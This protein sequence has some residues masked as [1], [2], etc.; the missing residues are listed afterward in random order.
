MTLTTFNERRADGERSWRFTISGIYTA[1]EEGAS[2][3]GLIGHYAYFN[4]GL[5]SGPDRVSW[6]VLKARDAAAN[7]ALAR[8]IDD[9]FANSAAATRTQSEAA[10][11]R[12]FLA[13]VGDIVGIVRLIVGAA[14]V[15]ILFVVGNTMVFSIAERT[16]EIGV[17]KTLGFS[18]GR[19]ARLVGGEALVLAV[20]GGLTGLALAALIVGAI[21]EP[22][23]DVLPGVA[24]TGSI[25]ATALGLMVL[26]ALLTGFVPVLKACRLNIV[27]ALGRD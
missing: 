25:W 10:L 1:A 24:L 14:F 7:D 13:Q 8:R 2:E 4:E 15:V 3:A 23:G 22:L 26:L 6:V 19:I 12:A 17:M 16:R 5:L 18:Q 9:S 20:A 21:A 11:G 27:E